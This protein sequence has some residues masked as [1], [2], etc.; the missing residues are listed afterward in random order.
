MYECKNDTCNGSLFCTMDCGHNLSHSPNA[1]NQQ[2]L[3]SLI[4]AEFNSMG[5]YPPY[6]YGIFNNETGRIA[7]ISDNAYTNELVH[8]QH[9]VSFHAST[10]FRPLTR[11]LDPG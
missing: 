6:V 11:G 1:I 5:L 8:T 10:E 4:T 2:Y 9:A 3:D 7:L